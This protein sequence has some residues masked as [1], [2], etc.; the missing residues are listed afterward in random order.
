MNI[1]SGVATSLRNAVNRVK[2]FVAARHEHAEDRALFAIACDDE[3]CDHYRI[4]QSQLE[5]AI[6]DIR[7]FVPTYVRAFVKLPPADI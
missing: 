5:L 3:A 4:V 2:A 1:L 7:I 6:R